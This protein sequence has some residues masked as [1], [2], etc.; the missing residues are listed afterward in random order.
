[1]PSLIAKFPDQSRKPITGPLAP[2]AMATRHYSYEIDDFG[3]TAPKT[4]DDLWRQARA[5]T[6]AAFVEGAGRGSL[7]AASRACSARTQSPN[8]SNDY[9]RVCS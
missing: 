1:M 2:G 9:A 8:Q 4:V 7:E 6:S 5:A 3:P